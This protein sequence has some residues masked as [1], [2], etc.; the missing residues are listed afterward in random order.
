MRLSQLAADAAACH[1]GMRGTVYLR[2]NTR[3][4]IEQELGLA[5]AQGQSVLFGGK[6][7]VGLCCS[8][9]H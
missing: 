5:A 8:A 2:G 7:P 9:G 6:C 4:L 3:A 1:P